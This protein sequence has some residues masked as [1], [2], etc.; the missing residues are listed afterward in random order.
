MRAAYLA[1]IA[2]CGSSSSNSKI[3]AAGDAAVSVDSVDA[4]A[5]ALGVV[6][7]VG[8]ITCPSGAPAQATCKQVTVTGCPGLASESIDA[9]IAV[10]AASGT[11]RG[12]I[13]H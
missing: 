9:T 10:L 2:A 11:V 3:D 13:V 12:T 5:S 4:P 8:D 7:V 6:T 1:V